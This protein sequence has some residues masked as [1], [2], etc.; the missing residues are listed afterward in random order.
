[1]QRFLDPEGLQSPRHRAF[2][3][4]G[5]HLRRGGRNHGNLARRR[6][7]YG[8]AAASPASSTCRNCSRCSGPSPTCRPP[9]CSTCPGRGWKAASR[10]S[11]PARCPTS[12]RALQQE[13]VARYDRLRTQKVDPREDNALAITTDGRKLALDARLL[14]AAAEDFPG[15]KVNALVD[16][17]AAIWQ[18]TA[19]T[20]GTQMIFCDM[21]VIPTPWGY[22]RL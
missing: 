3:R 6:V 11:S 18:R 8:P 17:V 19:P 9:R 16:N 2:R 4:L 13:L 5:R 20:R 15:S 7:A 10:S 22:S 1:M 14:S 12:R 21:G